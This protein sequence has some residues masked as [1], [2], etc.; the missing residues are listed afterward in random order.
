MLG[1]AR[2]RVYGILVLFLNE[3]VPGFGRRG[4]RGKAIDWGEVQDPEDDFR[5]QDRQRVTWTVRRHIQCNV[6]RT[7]AMISFPHSTALLW[8]RIVEV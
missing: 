7:Q 8:R 1:L 5:W 6:S 4:Q 3:S 2:G